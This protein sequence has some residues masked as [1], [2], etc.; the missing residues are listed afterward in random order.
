MAV[1]NKIQAILEKHI[2][3]KSPEVLAQMI[4][5]YLIED[6]VIDTGNG[7]AEDDPRYFDW[8]AGCSTDASEEDYN[9]IGMDLIFVNFSK[10][11]YNL[12]K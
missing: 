9:S 10:D 11:P 2:G 3:D 8:D 7:G 12:R 1:R 6:E 5:G 4:T